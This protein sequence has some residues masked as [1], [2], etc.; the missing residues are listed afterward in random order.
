MLLMA[1]AAY[2]RIVERGENTKRFYSVANRLVLAAL[3][4]LG[5]GISLDFYVVAQKII[6]RNEVA[7]GCATAL[8]AVFFGLWFGVTLWMRAPLHGGNPTR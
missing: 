1:P 7:L 8:A 2:H 5:I 6:H 4:P 3:V